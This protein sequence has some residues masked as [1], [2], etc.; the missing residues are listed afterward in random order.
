VVDVFSAP[1]SEERLQQ[2][3]LEDAAV[4]RVLQVVERLLATDGRAHPL[5]ISRG[6]RRAT[7]VRRRALHNGCLVRTTQ[8]M[9]IDPSLLR[10][11]SSRAIRA[12]GRTGAVASVRA[13]LWG[14]HDASQ[15]Q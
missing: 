10:R 3:I 11:F 1:G 12:R 7:G 5:G 15:E 4:E 2:R 14:P 9:P 6:R 13:S 8:E